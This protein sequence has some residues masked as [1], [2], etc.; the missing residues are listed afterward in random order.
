M[1]LLDK[2][3]LVQIPSGYGDGKLYS[4]KPTNGDGDFTFSRSSSGTRV[5]SDGLIETASVLGTTEEVTNGDFSSGTGWN[6]NPNWS[7]SG[8]VAIADGTSSSDI[9]QGTLSAV[10]GKKYLISFDV[11][12]LSQGTFLAKIGG[13][14][15]VG[16]AVG[17]FS[18]TVTA[19]STDRLRIVAQSNAIGTIDNVSV[20]EYIENDIPRLDYSGGASCASLLLEP[21]TQN[22]VTYSEDFSQ[23]SELTPNDLT[24]VSDLVNP[25]GSVGGYKVSRDGIYLGISLLTTTQRSIYARSVSGSGNVQLFTHNS[26]TNNVFTI[27][28]E[29]QRFD[30]NS[31]TSASAVG[32]YYIDL[33]GVLST[34]SELYVWGAQAT[35]DQSYV[36][37]YIPTSGS[38]VTRSADVCNG[39]GTSATFNDSE[40]VLFFEGKTTFDSS[41]SRRV[42][43]SDGSISNR[44][45][46]E[47]DESVENTIKAFINS[48]ALVYAANNLSI[49]NKIAFQ[50]KS[51]EH[52]LWING[53][54][55]KTSTNTSIPSGLDRLNFDGGNG[56]NDFYGNTKQLMVFDEALSDEELSDLTGQVNTSFA[57]LANFYN[58][59]IL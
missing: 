4:V 12:S 43:I 46:L 28:E 21:Q 16:N 3:S 57:E 39:A 8:G 2:A 26:N 15:V 11:V 29:W 38:T 36:T 56:G 34:L 49:Y 50:Y 35:N 9:N 47:F 54:E 32:N 14:G 27:T 37:S 53:N 23:W 10:I 33:R 52:K 6:Q 1:S 30:V 13:V 40:G 31:T 45:S 42:S 22:L 51:G 24:Y 5:N 59:T 20:I 44:V 41:L 55:V 48:S 18:A 19:T 25:D 7:I 17:S 58:Y